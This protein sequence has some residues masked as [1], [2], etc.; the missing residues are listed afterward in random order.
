MVGEPRAPWT[1]QSALWVVLTMSFALATTP[2]GA[3]QLPGAR[4]ADT[5]G[6][7]QMQWAYD[8]WTV[9]WVQVRGIAPAVAPASHVTLMTLACET[10][11]LERDRLARHLSAEEC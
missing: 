6:V 5:S 3:V 8:S 10:A 1:R 11:N 4:G 2:L 9:P 7:A